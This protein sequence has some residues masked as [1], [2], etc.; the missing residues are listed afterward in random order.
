MGKVTD[1]NRWWL[2]PKRKRLV[3]VRPQSL[4]RRTVFELC[5]SIFE[6]N[7]HR[8]ASLDFRLL[9][10]ECCEKPFRGC[11]SGTA[12]ITWLA[13]RFRCPEGSGDMLSGQKSCRGIDRS[14]K[15]FSLD[16]C[17]DIVE[18]ICRIRV[19]AGDPSAVRKQF[20]QRAL[21]SPFR[22]STKVVWPKFM[23]ELKSITA[24]YSHN[25]LS[26]F[27]LQ[28]SPKTLAGQ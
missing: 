22:V 14:R 10:P 27:T 9:W 20:V 25:L 23:G 28:Q 2:N 8:C 6:R 4:L 7:R 12:W 16:S 24:I 19:S 3:E 17:R 5:L 21:A 13:D 11:R 18:R 1:I 26:S 15:K